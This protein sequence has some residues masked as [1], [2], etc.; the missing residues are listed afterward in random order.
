MSEDSENEGSMGNVTRVVMRPPGHSGKAKKGHLCF[1]ASFECGNLGFV[2]LINQ[3]EYDLFIRPDT[4][5]PRVR[6]AFN[7]TVENSKPDQRV[8]MNII[9][10][11]KRRNCFLYGMTPIVKS[12]S[13]PNWQ[14]MPN[15]NVF[16][17]SSPY[18]NNNYV[19]SL[20]F[21]F[22][23]EDDVYEFAFC[24]PYSYTKCQAY[25]DLI[26]KKN[27]PYFRREQLGKSIQKRRVDLLTITDP[28][29]MTPNGKVHVVVVLSRIHPGE[30]PAS[31]VC[32]GIIDFLIS[33]QPTVISLREKVVFKIIPM[34]NPDGVYLGNQRCSSIGLDLNKSWSRISKWLHPTLDCT[35]SYIS[36]LDQD[37]N[38]ELDFVMDIH[39]HS[40]LRG[41]FIVGNTY[42]DVYRYERHIVFPKILSQLVLG[43]ENCH[44]VFN[45]DSNKSGS[46][47]R[48]LCDSLKDSVNCYSLNVSFYGY[49][50]SKNEPFKY[51]TE[52]TYFR[53]GR[54]V[55]QSFAEYYTSTGLIIPTVK[56][57]DKQPHLSRTIWRYHDVSKSLRR[58]HSAP[59]TCYGRMNV[60]DLGNIRPLTMETRRSRSYTRRR[61]R[62]RPWPP[63]AVPPEQPSLSIIDF[64]MMAR[65]GLE[66]ATAIRKKCNVSRT[67]YPTQNQ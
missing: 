56:N 44:T 28:K 65:G 52:E 7:F 67:G 10:F 17:H 49:Y 3:H 14:R 19:L 22:D 47:R 63:T 57:L 8:I 38:I 40:N 48:V 36:A 11:S 35:Y 59:G 5:N 1:D 29:N 30:S 60:V 20:A 66:Q 42:N 61:D 2:D 37:K 62:A 32:Q 9:N 64:N 31:F 41:A 24:Y 39:A 15:N 33:N 27:L 26:E 46:A 54:N 4:C 25:L 16:Y 34:L 50:H 53:V 23:K 18:H 45:R 43:Y 21:N 12:T 55:V 6:L 51:Y 58:R 13:R